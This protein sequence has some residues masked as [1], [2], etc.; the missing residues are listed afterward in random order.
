LIGR[1]LGLV[2]LAVATM[3]W[4]RR[5]PIR[6]VRLFGAVAIAGAGAAVLA[7]AGVRI[8]STFLATSACLALA[9]AANRR[10]ASRSTR[11]AVRRALWT[12]IAVLTVVPMR[13]RPVVGGIG[14]YAVG[15]AIGVEPLLVLIALV[16]IA[17]GII[18][19]RGDRLLVGAC[20]ALTSP[21]VVVV[22]R[23][24][25]LALDSLEPEPAWW[26]YPYWLLLGAALARANGNLRRP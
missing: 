21:L 3:L 11:P 9:F 15:V 23:F 12:L 25:L 6:P 4:A 16:Y 8:P 24:M 10:P 18:A 17:R 14:A 19:D 7:F 5:H 2:A 20:A 22:V 13:P 1:E 26:V